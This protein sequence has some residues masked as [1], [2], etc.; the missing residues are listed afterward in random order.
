VN[1]PL[2]RHWRFAAIGLTLAMTSVPAWT[3][4]SNV[5]VYGK[6]SSNPI[7]YLG[8]WLSE[9]ALTKAGTVFGGAHSR[10]L[11][12]RVD[13]GRKSFWAAG[14]WGRDDHGYRN[15]DLGLAELGLG[16]NFGTV[17]ANVA[18]GHGLSRQR[19]FLDGKLDTDGGY[20]LAELLRPFGGNLWGVLGGYYGW[21][22]VDIRRAY[23]DAFGVPDASLAS[24]DMRAWALRARLE[25][26]AVVRLGDVS[27]SPYGEL[28][29]MH[30]RSEGFTETGGSAPVVVAASTE[31][32]TDLRLGVHAAKALSGGARLLGQLEAVHRFGDKEVLPDK[33]NWLRLGAGAEVDAGGG[34][35]SLTL[36]LTTEGE[37]PSV[38]LAAAY[39]KAF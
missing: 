30:T 25:W 22:D 27:L 1:T 32:A 7:V 29:Y 9:D 31:H 16:Y 34:V 4:T 11:A 17:Q 19:G 14:D 24:T 13:A 35:A 37:V 10:P 8:D 26:D 5:D 38:W 23:L 20:L 21:S 3:A 15:A 2:T 12:S 18:F 36:N 33:P 28:V 6:F 39:R